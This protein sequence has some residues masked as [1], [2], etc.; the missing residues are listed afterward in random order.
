MREGIDMRM[1][2][3]GGGTGGHL[4]PGIAVA[5]EFLKRNPQNDV[6]FI[7]THRGLENR[8]LKNLGFSLRFIDI[9][10]IKGK[11]FCI[12]SPIPTPNGPPEPKERSD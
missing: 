3:A 4:F 6:L 9:E 7:G 8:V 12:P 1:I 5:E 10:G 2:I 11:S